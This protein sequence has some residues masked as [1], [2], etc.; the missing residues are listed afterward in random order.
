ML[1]VG[2][3]KYLRLCR[4]HQDA[5][6]FHLLHQLEP[7]CWSDFSWSQTGGRL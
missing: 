4:V 6:I 3:I 7:S 2:L 1:F 5:G